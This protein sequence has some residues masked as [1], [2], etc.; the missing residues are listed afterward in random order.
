M[1][2]YDIDT[3]LEFVFFACAVVGGVWVLVSFMIG[4]VR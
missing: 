2:R 4:M 1:K 3:V